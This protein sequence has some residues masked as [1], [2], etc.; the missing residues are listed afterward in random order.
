MT[1][2]F[3]NIMLIIAI[4]NALYVLALLIVPGRL[5]KD[6]QDYINQ[7]EMENRIYSKLCNELRKE[8]EKYEN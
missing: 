5:D 4:F 8:L 2:I 3:I 6:T 7:L 1:E